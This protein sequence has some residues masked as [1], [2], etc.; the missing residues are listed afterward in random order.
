MTALPPPGPTFDPR[1]LGAITSL[2]LFVYAAGFAILLEGSGGEVYGFATPLDRLTAV[3]ILSGACPI[4]SAAAGLFILGSF[5]RALTRS[6]A[7]CSGSPGAAA[8]LIAGL[9]GISVSLAIGFTLV[10]YAVLNGVLL[11]QGSP[12]LPSGSWRTAL[13]LLADLTLIFILLQFIVSITRRWYASV[14][15][16]ALYVFFVLY[17][18]SHVGSADLIGFGTTFRVQPT[19]YQDSSVGAEA[20]WLGRAYWASIAAVM[21]T[22]LA[23]FD[24]RPAP[25]LAFRA[26]FA[27][28]SKGRWRTAP[29]LIGAIC[30]A[31]AFGVFL[32]GAKADTARRYDPVQQPASIASGSNERLVGTGA[33]VRVDVR[34]AERTVG[35]SGSIALTNATDGPISTV[36]LEKAPVLRVQKIAAEGAE[37]EDRRI[38]PAFLVLTLRRPLPPHSNLTIHY[39]GLIDARDPFDSA[40]G[41]AVMREAV[42]LGTASILPL[43]R[44]PGC[45]TPSAA[46]TARCTMAENYLLSD[47]MPVSVHIEAPADMRFVDAEKIGATQGRTVWRQHV[48]PGGLANIL[49]AGARFRTSVFQDPSSGVVVTAFL[50]PH[51]AIS[52]SDVARFAA[53]EIAQ[54]ER[55]WP[56][57]A[58]RTYWIVEVPSDWTDAISYEGGAAV[59]ERYL[60]SR[61]RGSGDLA[62]TAKMVVSHEIAHQ[63]WGYAMVP[64]KLPGSAFVTESLAQFGALERL[65]QMRLITDEALIAQVRSNVRRGEKL[66]PRT[67]AL[68]RMESGDWRA[69]YEGPLALTMI[70]RGVPGGLMPILGGILRDPRLSREMP[71]DPADIVA[72]L[73]ARIPPAHQAEA[74]NALSP[75]SS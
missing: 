33:M 3:Q 35:I 44:R 25:L 8:R 39:R 65:R 23:G 34:P 14:L 54:Y 21:A 71:A 2:A 27:V 74:R 9:L 66:D 64:A 1:R 63:W 38:G 68:G 15:I 37:I 26:P 41:L 32:T 47:P 51:S 67:G 30:L 17:F 58:R 11:L 28:G 7:P 46:G 6:I 45:L 61:V 42:F 29:F 60:E 48:G 4:L 50:A 49:V 69:Y 20:A 53:G 75:P 5:D 18:G 52:A 12:A 73:I 10:S 57:L 72:A 22:V 70:D 19:L 24:R 62:M 36:A 16:F 31:S 43:P 59:S 56:R 55:W 13:D 40:A